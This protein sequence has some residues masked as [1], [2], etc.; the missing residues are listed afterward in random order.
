LKFKT[1]DIISRI[2]ALLTASANKAIEREEQLENAALTARYDWLEQH[3]AGFR[4]LATQ[5]LW[6]L[7]KKIPVTVEDIP[8]SV[9][10]RG[11]LKVFYAPSK[12]RPLAEERQAENLR[13][14]R[15]ALC[16]SQDETVSPTA[17]KQLGF[18][19]VTFLFTQEASK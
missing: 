14:L 8:D 11:D 10:Q 2:D 19:D 7:D 5:I 17:I 18:Q 13:K 4:E 9:R 12:G 3:E 16:A 15:N 6:C 1:A